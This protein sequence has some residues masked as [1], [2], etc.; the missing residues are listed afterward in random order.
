MYL[1]NICSSKYVLLIRII[2]FNNNMKV[3]YIELLNEPYKHIETHKYEI[4]HNCMTG[5]NLINFHTN[6]QYFENKKNII[7]LS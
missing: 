2:I 5:G 4:S 3:R 6:V 1:L 7:L